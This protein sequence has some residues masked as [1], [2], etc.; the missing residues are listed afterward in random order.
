MAGNITSGNLQSYELGHGTR[1]F[2]G[3][4][5]DIAMVQEMNW[6]PG[7]GD[8]QIRAW[9]TEAFGANYSYY[10]E[11]GAQIPNGVVSRYPILAAGAWV[12]P[13][14]DN[15]KFVW[16]RIDVPGPKD[17]WAIS[18]HLLTRSAS[19]RHSEA[20]ALVDLIDANVPATDYLVIGGDFNTGSR[21]EAAISTLGAVVNNAAPY[22]VDQGG[23]GGTNASRQSPYDWVM[24][25]PNLRALQVPVV[26]G[27][28]SLPNGLVFDS[29]VFTPLSAVAPV[30]QSDS[31]ASMMQHMAIVSDV[32]LPQ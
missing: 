31:G 12:D 6:F 2:Q 11:S 5:P 24:L 21:T 16:A 14:V 25:S 8:D 7:N 19:A 22:P 29:R 17:L 18:V 1:I 28:T 27:T 10:R 9:V 32:E 3:L 4:K 23:I 20:I 13:E 15:R 26:I 30:L